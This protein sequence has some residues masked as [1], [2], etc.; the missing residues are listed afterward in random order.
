MIGVV[1]G[2][3]IAFYASLGAVLGAGYFAA[4]RWNVQIYFDRGSGWNLVLLHFSRLVLAIAV[5]TLCA[6]QG[7]APLLASLAGFLAIRTISLQR[8]KFVAPGKP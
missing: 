1:P 3:R 8:Y 7:A 5:F 4:L 6:K 2:L